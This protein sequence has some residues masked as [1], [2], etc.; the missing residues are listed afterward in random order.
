MSQ[1]KRKWRDLWIGISGCT[2]CKNH[3]AHLDESQKWATDTHYIERAAYEELERE[4]ELWRDKHRIVTEGFEKM[5]EHA[6]ELEREIK[7]LEAKLQL[8]VEQLEPFKNGCPTK[9]PDCQC[10]LAAI[11]YALEKLK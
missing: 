2:Q 5:D 8:A 10:L 9:A 1:P 4:V 11:N 7:Q 3:V 6:Q